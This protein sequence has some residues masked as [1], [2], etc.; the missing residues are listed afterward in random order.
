MPLKLATLPPDIIGNILNG[1]SHSFLVIDLWK[2]GDSTLNKCLASGLT[3]LFLEQ[4]SPV[5]MSFPTVVYNLR[6]LR[7]LSVTSS[8]WLAKHPMDWS[9]VRS[10]LPKSLETLKLVA[11]DVSFVFMNFA[12][13]WSWENRAYVE[14]DYA[15]GKSRFV[16]IETLL[17]SL[18]SLKLDPFRSYSSKRSIEIQDLPGL[19]SKLTRLSTQSLD[20]SLEHQRL[21][22]LL[23]RSLTRLSGILGLSLMQ[24]D[25]PYGF[26]E[27][28]PPVDDWNG[29]PPHLERTGMIYTKYPGVITVDWLPRTV[30]R[31]ELPSVYELWT[32]TL[33]RSLPP[34]LQNL[35]VGTIDTDSFAEQQVNWAESLPRSLTELRFCPQ[36]EHL[37]HSRVALGKAIGLLPRGLKVLDIFYGHVHNL[38]PWEQILFN[39]DSPSSDLINWPPAL[40]S[41]C[42]NSYNLQFSDLHFLGSQIL[43]VTWRMKH[44]DYTKSHQI[45]GAKLPKNL[46]SL[47]CEAYYA[48]LPSLSVSIEGLLPSS[49]THFTMFDEQ[50]CVGPK[51]DRDCFEAL[52]P[53]LTYLALAITGVFEKDDPWTLPPSLRTLI[54]NGWHIKALKSIPRSMTS[55][56]LYELNGCLGTDCLDLAGDLPPGLRTLRLNVSDYITNTETFPATDYF[57][58]LPLLDTLSVDLPLKFRPSILR[59]LPRSLKSLSISID[60]L[61]EENA[62]F[63][64][65]RLSFCFLNAGDLLQQAWL[66]EKWPLTATHGDLKT[67]D[68]EPRLQ[69]I[70]EE[71]GFGDWR[72]FE[73]KDEESEEEEN[74]DT[75]Y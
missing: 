34:L 24:D 17:P 36:E 63:I 21:L 62:S 13:D 58:S 53:S 60:A 59:E 27:Q 16:D 46:T 42:V 2:C 50:S 9:E 25:E 33:A 67:E 37:D 47:A 40:D 23:P 44:L 32:A 54:L 12:P 19:P 51:F 4:D 71:R 43:T 31:C 56:E 35:S 73:K 49:L 6:A 65:P 70:R 48:D 26:C 74:T 15:L 52:P 10:K 3:H 20:T 68:L 22:S 66:L 1:Y 64:P 18:R 38:P 41:L 57:A 69:R 14:T 11:L 29:S 75:G 61:D 8:S 39:N 7:S 30:T 5:P 72:H 55:L 45:I 28:Q